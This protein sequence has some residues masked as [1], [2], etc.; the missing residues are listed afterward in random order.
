M[1]AIR[2]KVKRTGNKVIVELPE[3][4]KTETFELILFPIEDT[5]ESSLDETSEWKNFSVR[6]L[7]RLYEE[8][9]SD[10]SD[11]VVKEPNVKYKPDPK[12]ALLY[13]AEYFPQML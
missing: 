6:N 13:K 9:I 11:V 1:N 7:E 3:D 2:Q 8:E 5:T 10:Y 4:F 12:T